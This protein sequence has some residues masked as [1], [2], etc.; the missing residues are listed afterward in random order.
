MCG[1]ER[2]DALAGQATTESNLTLDPETV[3]ALVSEH[4]DACRTDTSHTTLTLKEIG[5]KRG[6]G[7]SSDLRAADRRRSN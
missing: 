4:F 7:R 1:N 2:A 5:V 6:A 3:L